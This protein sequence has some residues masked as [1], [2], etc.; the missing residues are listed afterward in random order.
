ML[1][2]QA[3]VLRLIHSGGHLGTALKNAVLVCTEA[4]TGRKTCVRKFNRLNVEVLFCPEIPVQTVP[5]HTCHMTARWSNDLHVT[6]L[7]PMLSV[8]A[9]QALWMEIEYVQLSYTSW[10]Q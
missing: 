5:I 6:S 9:G 10:L 7:T 8:S 2:H 1:K 3:S 4:E